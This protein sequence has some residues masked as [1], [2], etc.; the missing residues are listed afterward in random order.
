MLR[1]D[2]MK[3]GQGMVKVAEDRYGLWSE[4][5]YSKAWHTHKEAG[6]GMTGCDSIAGHMA[7]TSIPYL[8][9]HSNPNQPWPI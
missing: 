8:T 5:D 6:H 3:Y 9:V 2:F 4:G 1:K 7:T